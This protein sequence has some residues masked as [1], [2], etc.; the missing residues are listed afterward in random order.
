[1]NPGFVN[2]YRIVEELGRGGMGIVYKA[3]DP[4]LE[5]L[6]AVKIL[7]PKFV[8]NKEA[9][10]RFLREARVAAKLDHPNIVP[11]YDVGEDNGTYFMVMEYLEGKTL[12]EWLESRK[13]INLEKSMALFKQIAQ[14][15]DYAH[16]RKVIHRDIKP[17]NILILADQTIKVMDFGI[18]VMEDRHSVTQPGAVLGTIAYIS[19]EQAQGKQADARSDIYSLGI[20]LFELL[21][22]RLPF[23]ADTP[24]QMLAHHLYTPP[25][26]PSL[27]NPKV[28]G[29][30]DAISQKTLFKNPDE[31]YQNVGDLL[32]ELDRI[33]T[34]E[35]LGTPARNEGFQTSETFPSFI[36]ANPAV[37]N[38]EKTALIKDL[39]SL[40]SKDTSLETP[41]KSFSQDSFAKYRP[42]AARMEKD[43]NAEE[44]VSPASGDIADIQKET[45][46]VPCLHCGS[47]N[48][49]GQLSCSACGSLLSTE[50]IPGG[51]PL[52]PGVSL[53]QQ[54]RVEEAWRFFDDLLK[55]QP[56]L[57]GLYSAFCLFQLKRTHEA[58]AAFQKEADRN[59]ANGAV[60]EGL[61]DTAAG[62]SLNEDA[63]Q[64]YQEALRLVSAP[65]LWQ[66]LGEIQEKLGALDEA[67]QSF[68]KAVELDP[69]NPN[70]LRKGAELCIKTSKFQEAQAC[71]NRLL[72]ID[73]NNPAVQRLLGE[74]Y[75]R[76][77]REKE[78][79]QAYEKALS[80]DPKDNQVLTRL[81]ELHEKQNQTDLAINHLKK[82][83]KEG[84]N[85]AETYTKLAK[86]YLK[87][88]E[89]DSAL[90]YLE[91]ASQLNQTNPE[92]HK[93][94]GSLYLKKNA[95]EQ[96]LV[97]L[98]WTIALDPTDV[99]AHEN[100]GQLYLKRNQAERGI[101]EYKTALQLDPYNPS[102]HES[103]GMAYYTGQNVD[104]AIKEMQRAV[105]LDPENVEYRK[106]LGVMYE[107]QGNTDMARKEYQKAIEIAPKDALAQGLLGRIY[108]QQ[109]LT[110]LAIYQF[111]KSLECDPRSRLINS[112]LGKAY[113]RLEQ[114]ES[115]VASFRKAV[116][117]TPKTES[118]RSQEILGKNY[119][120]LGQSLL[121]I[122]KTEE[123]EEA[124]EQST[125]F[126]PT[127]AKAFH[128]LYKVLSRLGERQ[129]AARSVE[130]AA[131]L[132]PEDLEIVSDLGN[133]LD[134]I[135][136]WDA[137][138]AA[139]TKALQAAP[140]E[141]QYHAFLG[142]LY[143]RKGSLDDALRFYQKAVK[144]APQNWRYRQ[145]LSHVYKALGKTPEAL[146]ELEKAKNTT[147]I[148]KES[149]TLLENEIGKLKS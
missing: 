25:P 11:I 62:L 46:P 147:S 24:S 100:L 16:R 47:L 140:G 123:A 4:H 60:W 45:I 18:A 142:E 146:D 30:I 3:E 131:R 104:E 109:N 85:T 20:L 124:L 89:E 128:S 122:G 50:T 70:V 84:A 91:K 117:L 93:K 67:A 87:K 137:A 6:V 29:G 126:L 10:R 51:S 149:L 141:A 1:M 101:G 78:A 115:A 121:Q 21:T 79:F 105:M 59:P 37:E 95:L 8:N 106:A 17:D 74:F 5:R 96:A 49:T 80:L 27:F 69:D 148:S 57:S 44:G 77:N 120:Y 136:D 97:Q 66:K 103:L 98:E 110:H 94:L 133:T 76:T 54:G 107:A 118:V 56:T 72:K 52:E 48:P 9:L 19:P 92:L 130:K 144:L 55:K 61:G 75:E 42:A 139:F 143:F 71:L 53:Y 145:G 63:R 41:E 73:K 31:R 68:L 127:F 14:A 129:K 90:L 39:N 26:L 116:E 33:K 82:A 23:H 13:E 112:L 86:L 108:L 113:M 40:L 32:K 134:Y 65:L 64:A 12:R 38:P 132:D 35:F 43:A 135:Q 36:P 28:P 138:I 81:G 2:R 7:P 22:D 102:L 58:L 83:L 125:Q 111:Q 119:Y 99:E 34:S 114:F 15:L 88:N